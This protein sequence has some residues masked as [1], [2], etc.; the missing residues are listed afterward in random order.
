MEKFYASHGAVS[1]WRKRDGFTQKDY[2]LRNVSWYS[3]DILSDVRGEGRREGFTDT[4][5]LQEDVA[6]AKVKVAFLE[7]SA[8]EIKQ[9]E[10]FF[11]W[12]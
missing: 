5:T 2:A 10:K 4:F 8:K 3:S 9:V 1:E 11:G 6:S 7:E 12:G